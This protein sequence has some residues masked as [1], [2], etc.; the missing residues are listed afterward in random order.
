MRNIVKIGIGYNK[1]QQLAENMESILG[2]VG[3]IGHLD[4]IF[5][6]QNIK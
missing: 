2:N 3:E 1:I 6:K 5:A 4:E